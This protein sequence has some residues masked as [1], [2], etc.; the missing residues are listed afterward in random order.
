MQILGRKSS[1]SVS[2]SLLFCFYFEVRTK[3]E[4]QKQ[5]SMILFASF[6]NSSVSPFSPSPFSELKRCLFFSFSL[7]HV[8]KQGTLFLPTLT[9]SNSCPLFQASLIIHTENMI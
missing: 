6:L 1:I 4:M 5:F 8:N 9:S 7:S 3:V 2:L